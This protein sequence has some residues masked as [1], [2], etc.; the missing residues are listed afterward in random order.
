MCDLIMLVFSSLKDSRSSPSEQEMA[1]QVYNNLKVL[2]ISLMV[3]PLF[4][5]LSPP[6]LLNGSSSPL[7]LMVPPLFSPPLL[8]G[9]S[10]P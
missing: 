9:S 4:S 8:N 2:I 7:S 6:P 5:P 1:D 10:S 3:P